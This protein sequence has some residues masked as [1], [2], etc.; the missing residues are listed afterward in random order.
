MMRPLPVTLLVMGLA[1]GPHMGAA[2]WGLSADVGVASFGGTSRDSTGTTVG[3]YRPTTFAVRVDRGEGPVRIAVHV[4]YAEPG[5]AGKQSD[6]TFVQSGVMSLWEIVPLVA[7]RVVRFGTG[8][9]GRFEAGPALDLWDFD[10]E[11]RNRVGARGGVALQWPLARSLTGSLRVGGVWSE[12][13]VDAGDVPAGVERVTT[14]RF[15]VAIGLRYK[16]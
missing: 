11:Q 2:Q 6:L 7:V 3:P 13:V 10:G 14:R 5:L 15:D 16:L 8:V 9:E 12:S 1:A 4:L